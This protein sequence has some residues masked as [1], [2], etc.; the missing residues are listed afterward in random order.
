[1]N[2]KVPGLSRLDVGGG[3][4]FIRNFAKAVKSFSH[5]VVESGDYDVLLIAGASLSDR[6]TVM[7]AKRAGKPIVLRVDNILEDSKNRSTGMSRMREFAELCDVVVY[8]SEWAKRLLKPYCGN[9]MIIRNGVDT[10]VFYPRKEAKDWDNLRI[11]YGKFSRGE[12][13]NFNVVQY[14]WREY[15]LDKDGDTL[16]LAGR[17]ADEY[18]KINHPFEFHNEE[19]YEYRGVLDAKALADTIRS[20]DVAFLPY[21]ADAAPNQVLEAQACGLPVIYEEYG[22]TQEMVDF[23]VKL[24]W[25]MSPVEMVQK[26][27]ETKKDFDSCKWGL[28]RMGREWSSLFTLLQAGTFD[29]E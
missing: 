17:F 13:K 1:M 10:D 12:G 18:Q 9:G 20:C 5:S 15:C 23:G 22:G 7:E 27:M 21:F 19:E 2:I 14:W 25:S 6:E 26:A 28:E 4:S 11:F 8:Q 29:V 16:V 3:A 24:D